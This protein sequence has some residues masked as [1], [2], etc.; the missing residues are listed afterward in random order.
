MDQFFIVGHVAH[1]LFICALI[2]FSN[3]RANVWHFN[4]FV[5]FAVLFAVEFELFHEVSRLCGLT[6][7]GPDA[8]LRV[9]YLFCL[10]FALGLFYREVIFYAEKH[11]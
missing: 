2:W 1:A 9:R 10:Y 11:D 8:D 4:L 7:G 3:R 6:S 5:A